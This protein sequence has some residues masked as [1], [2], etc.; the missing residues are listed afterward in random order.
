[1]GLPC[2]VH[3]SGRTL[4]ERALVR[5]QGS[6]Q[7]G[8]P[9]TP[10]QWTC[11]VHPGHAANDPAR[12]TNEG[13]R[14]YSSAGDLR[15]QTTAIPSETRKRMQQQA[16]GATQQPLLRGADMQSSSKEHERG[17]TIEGMSCPALGE[18][19]AVRTTIMDD[20]AAA[21]RAAQLWAREKEA[22]F[23]TGGWMWS[24]DGSRSDDGRV[25]AAAVCKHRNEWKSRRS[26]LVT[27]RMEVFNAELWVIGSALDVAIEKRET[28]QVHG[29]KTF[30]VFSDSQATIRRAAH[31]EPGP[32][33]QLARRISM[34]AWSLLAHGIATEIHWVP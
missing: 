4:W 10:P 11:Q 12:R 28:L 5:P 24:T 16:K 19:P 8:R 1:M 18:E 14:A 3:P 6:W 23:G 2:G 15:L 21:K 26:F 9:P 13:V 32:G 22:K 31:L 33:Q 34:R 29:V 20:T 30:A 27:G 17:R 7:A 25:G